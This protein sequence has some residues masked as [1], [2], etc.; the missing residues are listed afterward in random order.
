M[1]ILFDAN[2]SFKVAGKVRKLFEVSLH[3]SNTGLNI[4]AKD[5]EI[6]IYAK[7]N[8]FTIITY[9]E[10][11]SDF[12][13]IYGAPPKV[14]WLRFGNAPVDKI[15]NKIETHLSDIQTFIQDKDTEILE[16]Y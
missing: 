5:D 10:D 3:V 15:I 13:N 14:I 6:W 9:D 11:F 7:N 4:P 1:K 2:I 16:I 12:V 8:N